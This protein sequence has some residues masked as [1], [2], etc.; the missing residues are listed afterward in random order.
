M[1]GTPGAL[2]LHLCGILPP[3]WS[4]DYIGAKKCPDCGKSYKKRYD[5]LAHITKVHKKVKNFA[6]SHCDYRASVPF[7]LTK[8]IRRMHNDQG[9]VDLNFP[10]FSKISKNV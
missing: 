10:P 6:C 1:F 9:N 4:G 8:H 2:G 5:L 3:R 7:L